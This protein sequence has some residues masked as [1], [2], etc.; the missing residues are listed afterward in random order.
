MNE[1]YTKSTDQFQICILSLPDFILFIP[2][3]RNFSVLD[4][5]FYV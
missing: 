4:L 1:T 3:K 2:I 5:E